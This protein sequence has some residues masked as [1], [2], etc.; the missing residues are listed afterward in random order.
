MDVS[1]IIVNYK[2]C[3]LTL[4]CLESIYQMTSGVDFEVILVDNHSADGSVDIIGKKFP[5]VKLVENNNNVGFGRANNVGA[6]CSSGKYL[7]LLNSDTILVENV[8]KVFFDYME[9]HNEYAACGCNLV[10]KEGREVA[11]HG[12]LPS[13]FM[14]IMSNPLGRVFSSY[15]KNY[16]SIGQTISYGNISDTGYISGADIFVRAEI[17]NQFKGFDP[18]IF[19][20]FEET[21]LFA[22]MKR[23]GLRFCVI[24][25]HKIVHLVGS[26]F[27][28]DKKKQLVRDKMF[29]ESH[30]YYYRKNH[31]KTYAKCAKVAVIFSVIFSRRAFKKEI[32]K[33][34]INA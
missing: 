1:I 22:R 21:D 4:N 7:F 16:L 15:Y 17:F 9:K 26:S 32:I 3:S 20:Y 23:S 28:R 2:T 19:M 8:V 18:N 27:N 14:E 5:S 6:N 29:E 24:P 30:V 33:I 11:C 10:D 12:N 34:V 13:L 31:G 25:D